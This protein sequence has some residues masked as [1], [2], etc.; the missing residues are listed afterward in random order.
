MAQ[1]SDIMDFSRTSAATYTDA[2]GYVA[3]A[4]AHELR[5]DHDPATLERIGYLVEG[6]SQN[7]LAES[8]D[9][10][11]WTQM[12]VSV[13][14][15]AGIGP[16]G[17]VSASLVRE[18]TSATGHYV[19]ESASLTTGL[20]Y[21]CSVWMKAAGRGY[22]RIIAASG[23]GAG[24]ETVAVDLATG[25]TLATSGVTASAQQY[26]D[27]WWRIG[28]SG[29]ATASGFHS[30][31]LRL[32]DDL[33]T[34]S[35]SYL[36]DGT[37][38]VLM[39]GAQV[40]QQSFATSY[41]PT[42]GAAVPRSADRAAVQVAPWFRED[43]YTLYVQTRPHSDAVAG[44]A[45]SLNEPVGDNYAALRGFAGSYGPRVGS[46]GVSVVSFSA[47]PLVAGQDAKIA[48]ACRRDDFALSA[49]G[50]AVLTDMAGEMPVGPDVLEVGRYIG[51]GNNWHG[52]IRD[53]R[54]YPRRL[55]DAELQA[56]TA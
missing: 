28:L 25:A 24:V 50:G 27:G 36:G 35:G 12:A 40:E 7:E 1:L 46:Q 19:S 14:A 21:S 34:S 52:H 54:F 29:T 43:E 13:V 42:S 5:I 48:F 44:F 11:G 45:Y 53:L 2:T 3:T 4:A 20:D 56:I 10:S 55:T 32:A 26:R 30:F 22:A 49:D 47:G 31:Q 9:F 23:M 17:L 51:D 41:I 38:G 16:D 15:A 8:E 33:S 6:M 39:W 37:S 18:N